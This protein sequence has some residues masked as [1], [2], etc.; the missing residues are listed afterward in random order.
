MWPIVYMTNPQQ[1]D[2]LSV[3]FCVLESPPPGYMS[4]DGD[5]QAVGKISYCY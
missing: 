3:A 5:S 2:Q 4:E 1:N